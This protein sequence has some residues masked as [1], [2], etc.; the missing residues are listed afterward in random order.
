[1]I[2]ISLPSFVFDVYISEFLYPEWPVV[3]SHTSYIADKKA[4]FISVKHRLVYLRKDKLQSVANAPMDEDIF[5][6]R[7]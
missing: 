3:G 2:I 5:S 1:M 4:M 6:I 7:M